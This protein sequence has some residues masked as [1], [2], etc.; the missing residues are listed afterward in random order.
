MRILKDENGSVP[1]L[2]IG[3][4]AF[5]IAVI[6]GVMIWYKIDA[7]VINGFGSRAGV[8]TSYAGF[9][10]TITSINSSA[11]STWA[12][13]PIVGLVLIAGVII[14]TIMMFAGGKKL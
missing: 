1:G 13:A 12:L 5:L 7:A 4:V 14:A 6:I 3:V 9:N 10:S 2:V 8:G 11:N